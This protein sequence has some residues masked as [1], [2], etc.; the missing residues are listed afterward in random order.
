MLQDVIKTQCV[1][2]EVREMRTDDNVFSCWRIHSHSSSSSSCHIGEKV[3]ELM[4]PLGMMVVAGGGGGRTG[5]STTEKKQLAPGGTLIIP[6][7]S[8]DINLSVS[9]T[10]TEVRDEIV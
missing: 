8:G 9:G 3:N 1:R 10:V 5:D 6:L 4:N 2:V 7:V